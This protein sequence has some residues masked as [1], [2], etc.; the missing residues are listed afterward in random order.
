MP[1]TIAFRF[2]LGRYHATPWDRTVNEGAVEWPPSPWRLLR[3]LVST[4]HLRAQDAV[5]EQQLDEVLRALSAAP[6]YRVPPTG[7]GHSRHY[8]PD[9]LRRSGATG[10][11]DLVLDPFLALDPSAEL[12]V[13]WADAT[14]TN[15]QRR[16]LSTLVG[17]IPYLGRSESV[18]E[19]RVVDDLIDSAAAHWWHPAAPD[20]ESTV[21]LLASVDGSRSQ[22]E[23]TPHTVRRSKLLTP[24]GSKWVDY[25]E[26][27]AGPRA[28]PVRQEF[29]VIT[30]VRWRLATNAPFMARYG[31]LATDRLRS[32]V[33]HTV[34]RA[35]G[36]AQPPPWL[37]GKDGPSKASDDHQHAHWLWT[38][39]RNE[40]RDLVLWVPG[41]IAP[42]HLPMVLERRELR[43]PADWTP[44]GFRA[45]D[46]HLV[47]VGGAEVLPSELAGAGTAWVSQHPY[48]PSRHRKKAQ[49]LEQFL[50]ADIS[51]ELAHRGLPELASLDVLDDGAGARRHR[52]HRMHPASRRWDTGYS[53]RLN[54][55][56]DVCGPLLLGGL[57]HFGF[58]QFRVEG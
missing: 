10:S 27:A 18:C 8:M 23:V 22:L 4:W 16:A 1:V 3:A 36:D 55:T 5:T 49:T 34:N 41:G 53:V 13:R 30:T 24:A 35:L 21:R 26:P 25:V 28:V 57:S 58:G 9:N 52:R 46:L 11:T 44:E 54:L 56:G 47:G 37:S 43:G 48:L 20:D 15:E 40:V 38:E 39:A 6:S 7:K 19:G 33:L 14:L 17:R 31:V 45:G 51:R 12:V 50:S 32:G 2:P 42:R 29:P